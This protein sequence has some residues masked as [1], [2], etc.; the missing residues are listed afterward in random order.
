M[1]LAV[2]VG[3]VVF[4]VVCHRR[5]RNP[6][7]GV[8][9]T[10]VWVVGIT[11]ALLLILSGGFGLGAFDAKVQRLLVVETVGV[12]VVSSL[13][14][15]IMQSVRTDRGFGK[16]FCPYCKFSFGESYV[17]KCPKCARDV[18]W[19]QFS[20]KK[21]CHQCGYDLRGLTERRCPECGAEI[22]GAMHPAH[23]E[24]VGDGVET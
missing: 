12:A 11:A 4:S 24:D 1:L 22:I 7:V 20:L 19:A 2:T 14:A 15:S 3:A 8:L 10:V 21:E 16:R 17:W 6:V 13:T 9:W 18:S 5:Y 23:D